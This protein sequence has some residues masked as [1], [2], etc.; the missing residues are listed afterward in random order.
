MGEYA[1]NGQSMK[2]TTG[3]IFFDMA[4]AFDRVW[5]KGLIYKMD[6][7]GYP[8]NIVQLEVSYLEDRKFRVR[9]G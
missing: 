5:H 6:Q 7:M 3:M 9:V 8:E 2:Y 1:T 4:N